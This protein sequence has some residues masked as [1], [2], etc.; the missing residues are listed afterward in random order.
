MRRGVRS[1]RPGTPETEPDSHQAGDA[2][3]G[4][5]HSWWRG[6]V[7]YQIYVPSFADSTADGTGDLEGIRSRLGYL[8]L[9]GIDA[10][11]L[12]PFYTS[13]MV[14]NGYDIAD[15]RSVDPRF[16]DLDTFDALIR[17]A[18][19]HGIRVVI[20]LVPNHTSDKHDW[21]IRAW[22]AG[23][24]SQERGRYIFRKGSGPG[25]QQ[26]PNNWTSVFGGPAWT[27]VHDGPESG[28][29]E[30]YLH[31]FAPEQPDLNWN[32]DEVRA[33]FFETMRFWLDRGVDGF[34]IDV[35]HGMIK[36][37]DLTDMDPRAAESVDS[38]THFDPRFDN[39]EVHEVHRQ[40]RAVLDEYTDRVAIGE[41]STSDTERFARYVGPDELHLGFNFLLARTRFDAGEIQHAITTSME[42]AT[43][44]GAPP[45]W[46]PANHDVGRQV[47][48]YG[49]GSIGSRRAGAMALVTL[50][51]PGV[52]CLYNGEELGLADVDIPADA[53]TDPIAR[54]RPQH[55]G[56]DP[57]RVPIPWEG[58]SPPYAF[59]DTER[60][61]LPMPEDW[62]GQTVSA[63]LEDAASMLSLYRSA[64][65]LR[66]MHF[67]EVDDAL[68]WSTAP[69]GC[70]AFRRSNGLV[71]VLN[72]GTEPV[73]L[74]E[75]EVLLSSVEITDGM[76]PADAAA[77]IR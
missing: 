49:G 40:I 15:P 75:G 24:A 64:I 56:R 52:V 62:A 50:A 6:A 23:S 35:A 3:D 29:D 63:Q 53:I 16:G 69:R 41:V 57:V 14:D 43:R 59:S 11:W 46:M 31:L 58:S 38:G 4:D 61:W 65:E 42:A 30:W 74:P 76:L 9:L 1:N 73:Q 12:T 67:G 47:S 37:P 71:C 68:E 8:E 55:E 72:A 33:D 51:L 44:Y 60:T 17:D 28:P 20:D 25:G 10:L 22:H 18:H 66:A 54:N 26:P 2:G 34:R 21:F 70:L 45:T 5:R 77:W 27:R 32:N 48:R 13:P 36:Q 39:D 19:T 7:I